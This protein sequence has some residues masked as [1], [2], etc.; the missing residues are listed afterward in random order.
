MSRRIKRTKRRRKR[1]TSR[2]IIVRTVSR[3][4]AYSHDIEDSAESPESKHGGRSDCDHPDC[5]R[6]RRDDCSIRDFTRNRQA[7]CGRIYNKVV[8]FMS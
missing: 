2:I 5:S 6:S 1:L 8:S 3:E 7:L 4:R